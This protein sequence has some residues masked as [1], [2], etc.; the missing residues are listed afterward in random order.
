MKQLFRISLFMVFGFFLNTCAISK[1]ER[2]NDQPNATIVFDSIS[3]LSWNIQDLGKSKTDEEITRMATII[4]GYDL[5]AIQEV[6]GG[7]GGVEAVR[8]L[9]SG[10]NSDSL[11]F[12]FAVSEK[13]K[14]SSSYSSE[15]YAF[16]WRIS[17]LEIKKEPRLLSY[18]E[19]L[20]DREPYQ[21]LFSPNGCSENFSISTFHAVSEKKHPE[22]EV[23]HLPLILD[24]SSTQDMLICGDFNLDEDDMAWD[25]LYVKGFQNVLD[26]RSTSLKMRCKNG[27]YVNHEF[28]N[29]FWKGNNFVLG[30]GTVLDEVKSCDGLDGFRDLSDHLPIVTWLKYEKK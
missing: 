26:D 16:I 17:T 27:V 23:V 8:R 3:V 30:L 4:E 28:D 15:R 1:Q 13:T 7:K 21:A 10:L 19:K 18:L 9:M 20:C 2:G 25:S 14:S 24:S 22:R 6:V 5:I 12:D 11:K 29:F